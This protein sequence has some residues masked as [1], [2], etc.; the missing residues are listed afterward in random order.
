MLL[1]FKI[2][3]ISIYL[4]HKTIILS[5]YVIL[6]FLICFLYKIKKMSHKIMSIKFILLN[7]YLNDF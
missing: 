5:V 4:I 7:Y 3:L 6:K 1:K 2:L